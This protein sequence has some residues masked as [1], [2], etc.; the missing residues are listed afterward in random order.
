MILDIG[1]FCFCRRVVVPLVCKTWRDIANQP[2]SL[3][4]DLTINLHAQPAPLRSAAQAYFR[5]RREH[6]KSLHL[7]LPAAQA[8]VVADILEAL[9]NEPP[10]KRLSVDF[11]GGS[12]AT[13]P[14]FL[15]QLA[16]LRQLRALRISGL[17]VSLL[18]EHSASSSD[19]TSF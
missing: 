4:H 11:G 14:A 6:L 8:T 5:K 2:S 7:L 17:Q 12:A 3:W 19:A 16:W 15:P 18:H 9:G 13:I 10:L 1:I